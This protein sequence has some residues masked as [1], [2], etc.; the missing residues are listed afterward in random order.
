[1]GAALP[2]TMLV[3]GSAAGRAGSRT[4]A[5]WPRSGRNDLRVGI[6]KEKR[7]VDSNKSSNKKQDNPKCLTTRTLQIE[8]RAILK[9]WLG[10][11][12]LRLRH[13]RALA[14]QSCT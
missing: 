2:A 6:S 5:D 7:A 1:M 4:Q 12:G 9:P 11:S 10:I 14:L 3:L 13:A 8:N